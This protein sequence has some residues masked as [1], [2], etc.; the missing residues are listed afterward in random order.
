LENREENREKNQEIRFQSAAGS[1]GG[2]LCASVIASAE[3]YQLKALEKVIKSE[4]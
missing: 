2:E 1:F 4:D 3:N